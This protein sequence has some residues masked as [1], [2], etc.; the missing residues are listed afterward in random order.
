MKKIL[1]LFRIEKF[2]ARFIDLMN[3]FQE[4]H[5]FW[6]F[7]EELLN[8]SAEYLK[9]ANV[10][11]Y[12]RIDIKMNKQ[13]TYDELR[14]Y[15]L[16]VYHGVFDDSVIQFF[17]NHKEILKKLALY[18]W[19]G[20]KEFIREW[21]K[22]KKYVVKN[23]AAIVTIIPQDYWELKKYYNLKGKFFCAGYNS[24]NIFNT[25]INISSQAK[26]Q[27]TVINIQV[28]NSA[29][30]TNNHINILKNLSK[31]KEEDINV[32]VPLSYGDK[33]YAE[34]V[35][36]Y[37]KEILGDKFIPIQHFMPFEEY[38]KY[39]YKMD[40]GI[41][42]IKRQQAMGNIVSL[43]H[44]GCKIYLNPESMMWDF[45]SKDLGCAVS[46]ASQICKMN[47]KEFAA[48]SEKDVILNRNRIRKKYSVEE[49]IR[50][51]KKVYDFFG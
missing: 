27:N 21:G 11:Y 29:T 36:M 26:P 40:V 24:N 14:K 20:D 39:L 16:I 32:Y 12:P 2:T 41:F 33:K 37:G 42:D 25:L 9:Y 4:E 17:Y 44:M 50:D 31:F 23:A 8:D 19:G 15:D 1:H 43:M 38:C 18:F 51:W 49:S 46:D 30:T 34:K 13:S 10:R 3:E 7:G 6:V 47:I 45:F 48:F 5:F 35:I 28:G 22:G